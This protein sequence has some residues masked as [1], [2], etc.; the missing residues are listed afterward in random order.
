LEIGTID[1]VKKI[2]GWR[3]DALINDP[4]VHAFAT[5]EDANGRR[6]RDAQAVGTVCRNVNKGTL[7]EIGTSLGHTTALMAQNAP[8]AHVY[9]INIP[10]EKIADGRGGVL[11]TVAYQ[12]EEI[13]SYYRTLR[14]ANI[15]Q[16]IENSA[17]WEPEMNTIDVAFIDGCHDSDFVFNDTR[18]ML[19]RMRPGSF[20]L[21]HDFNPEL[22]AKYSWIRSVC[23]GVERLFRAGLLRGRMYHLRDSWVGI[24]RVEKTGQ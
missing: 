11:T 20:V 4:Q 5:E 13:G 19:K 21:W 8:G 23:L 10:P 2:F 1:D 16:V 3:E 6:V 22:A 18:K 7:V 17:V 24:Y 9:T 14:L 12:R 15:T